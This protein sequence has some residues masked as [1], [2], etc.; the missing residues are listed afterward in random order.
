MLARLAVLEAG[1]ALEDELLDE[2]E[3]HALVILE[4][5][6]RHAALTVLAARRTL[7]LVYRLRQGDHGVVSQPA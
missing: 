5:L 1:K 6:E 4:D 2:I 3:G 7:D